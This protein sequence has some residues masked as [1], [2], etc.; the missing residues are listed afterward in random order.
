[1]ILYE[2]WGVGNGEQGTGS[3]EQRAER[4]ENVQWTFLAMEPGGARGLLKE[5]VAGNG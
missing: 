2:E 3:R 4:K 1:L 5:W